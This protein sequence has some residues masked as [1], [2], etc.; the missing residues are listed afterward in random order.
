MFK[1]QMNL[2]QSKSGFCSARIDKAP[3]KEVTLE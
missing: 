1:I 2:I 3:K